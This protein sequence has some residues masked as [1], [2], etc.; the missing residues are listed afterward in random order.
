MKWSFDDALPCR[1]HEVSSQAGL[2]AIGQ[3]DR[4]MPEIWATQSPSLIQQ[5]CATSRLS[6]QPYLKAHR[7]TDEA[8][9]AKSDKILGR[10]E[11]DLIYLQLAV[12]SIL[13]TGQAGLS[14]V[15]VCGNLL[16]PT[17]AHTQRGWNGSHHQRLLSGRSPGSTPSER[18]EASR[19]N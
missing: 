1:V 13:N 16:S 7:V 5:L 15:N 6:V 3:T 17:Q 19:S 18:I 12:E 14:I 8:L 10:F 9:N 4:L 11:L 2:C